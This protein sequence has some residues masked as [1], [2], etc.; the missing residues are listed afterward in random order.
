MIHPSAAALRD[1]LSGR[2]IAAALTPTADAAIFKGY[3][4]SLV[5]DGAEAL[6]VAA[7]TGRGPHLSAAERETV[8]KAAQGLGVPVLVGV[9]DAAQ[10][11]AAASL[12]ADGVLV[13]PPLADAPA[14]HDEIWSAGGLPMIAFDLYI[15][16]YP[17]QVLAR[18]LEHPGV[19]GLK[20][21]RLHDA[22]ACQHGIAAA[23]AAD[24]LA[25]TGEDR[26]FGASLMW[27]AQAALVGLAA[28]SVSITADTLRAWRENRFADFVAAS[29]RTDAFAGSTFFEPFDGY[30]QRLQWIAAA[31]GRFPPE[32]AT[33]PYAPPL[34]GEGPTP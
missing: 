24:R 32:Y 1:K 15:R 26:M 6:A 13:F 11:R 23:R 31:E 30:V 20:L 5:R 16:P 18:V 33:D 9:E 7:H 22:I 14:V 2:L 21:A 34:P 29:A 10:A 8:V 28:A 19:A 4:E 3:A 27:G 12:G 25:I 17:P